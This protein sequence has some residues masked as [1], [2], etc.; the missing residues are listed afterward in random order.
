MEEKGHRRH[1]VVIIQLFIMLIVC[2]VSHI[3][4]SSMPVVV[5]FGAPQNWFKW[6][7]YV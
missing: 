4:A 2:H 5:V 6:V 3:C 7:G 1:C